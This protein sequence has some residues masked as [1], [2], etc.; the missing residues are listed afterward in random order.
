[1]NDTQTGRDDMT[2]AAAREAALALVLSGELGGVLPGPDEVPRDVD[3]LVLEAVE[4]L[5]DQ[6]WD[7][8]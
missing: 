1:M 2:R 8:G 5:L 7:R 4:T 3:P 6:V